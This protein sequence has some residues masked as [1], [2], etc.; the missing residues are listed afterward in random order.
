[1]P[2]SLQEACMEGLPCL[3][4]R[5]ASCQW[6]EGSMQ[7]SSRG[8]MTSRGCLAGGRT[9]EDE[10]CRDSGV[11]RPPT[12]TGVAQGEDRAGPVRLR[13]ARTPPTHT[14]APLFAGVELV[15][16]RSR[17]QEVARD[18]PGGTCIS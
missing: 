2:L 13:R 5:P 7:S 15:R 1:M 11:T 4:L 10:A 6:G 12:D 14:Q 18:L 16:P 3:P 17:L 8:G 9:L